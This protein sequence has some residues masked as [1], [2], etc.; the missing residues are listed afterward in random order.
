MRARPSK[1]SRA[2]D[3]PFGRPRVDQ[4][5]GSPE[6]ARLKQEIWDELKSGATVE[7]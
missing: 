6:M 3:V 4:V 1:I 7:G 5:R 2:I